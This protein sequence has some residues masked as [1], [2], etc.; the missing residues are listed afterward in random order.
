MVAADGS[1]TVSPL[2]VE[3]LG[4]STPRGE[5]TMAETQ[6]AVRLRE[7]ETLFLVRAEMT[8]DQVDKLKERARGIVNREGGKLIRFTVTGKKK[9][10]F[11]VE[12]AGRAIYVHAHFLGGSGV[13][14]ELERNLRNIDDVT[15]FLTIKL[16]DE[17]DPETRPVQEDVKVA[18]DADENRPLV[19]GATEGE[20]RSAAAIDDSSE[21]GASDEA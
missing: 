4:P 6:S 10:A 8:D 17:V 5:N 1:G 16:G 21:E 13:V 18:G 19:P 7:Y 12:K 15:R 2:Q 3:G 14:A 11:P 20:H 9:T